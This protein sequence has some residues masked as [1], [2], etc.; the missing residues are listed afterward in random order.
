MGKVS[1]Q[2]KARSRRPSKKDKRKKIQNHRKERALQQIETLHQLLLQ[3]R[4]ID[5]KRA[6]VK[7]MRLLAQK[8]QLSMPFTLKNS[9]C[10]RC[11]E[12]FILEPVR[13]FSVRVRS[14]PEPMIVYTCLKC[15]YKRKKIYKKKKGTDS[16]NDVK[17]NHKF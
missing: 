13:T 8:V 15:G 4:D 7:H 2:K 16:P 14:K 12:P 3:T 10:R 1:E 11:S 9:F 6:Y 17:K 5:L